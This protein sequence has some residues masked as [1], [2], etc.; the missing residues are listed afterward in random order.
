MNKSRWRRSGKGNSN[1]NPNPRDIYQ[2]V[3]D[4]ILAALERGV[5]PWQRGWDQGLA[6][7]PMNPTTGRIYRGINNLLLGMM[8]DAAFN[9]DPR[10]CS[11]RQAQARGWQVR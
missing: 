1:L 5:L 2:E 7:A 6:G 9:G 11:Y 4:K 8:Q 10:W 3:T